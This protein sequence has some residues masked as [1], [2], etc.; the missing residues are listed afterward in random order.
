MRRKQT[1]SVIIFSATVSVLALLYFFVDARHSHLF[2]ACPFF[3]LTGL[4]CPGCG[5]QRAISALL[6]ADFLEAIGYNVMLVT[7]A[8][9]IL[10]SASVTV[11]NVFRTEPL[12]QSIF[13]SPLFVRL[14]LVA[15]VLFAVLRNIAIYPFTLLAP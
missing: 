5:S 13:Y 4:Y 10:Y 8:P 14:F 12:V 2:P 3:T 11:L 7:S 15:V 9:L 6:H 1:L